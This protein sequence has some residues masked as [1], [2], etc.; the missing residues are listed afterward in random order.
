[1]RVRLRMLRRRRSTEGLRTPTFL[2]W[3]RTVGAVYDRPPC[4][5]SRLWAVIDRPYSR[6]ILIL[7]L[8]CVQP[9]FAQTWNYVG[10]YAVPSRILSVNS[11]PRSDS[12]IYVVAA[13]GGIWKTQNGGTLWTHLLDS[14]P[15]QLCSVALDPRFPDVLYVGTGDDQSPRPLQGI[16][17]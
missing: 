5:F 13:G 3:I 6:L 14:G 17:R 7:A 16:A 2:A 1:R 9:A 4:R 10:P 11:D 8:L 12:T 15:E